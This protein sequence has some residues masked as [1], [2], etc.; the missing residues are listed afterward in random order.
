MTDRWRPD[1]TEG[2][3]AAELDLLN[4]AQVRLESANPEVDPGNIADRIN[5]AWQPGITLLELVAKAAL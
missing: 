4:L 2:F 5:N 3:S 1:N